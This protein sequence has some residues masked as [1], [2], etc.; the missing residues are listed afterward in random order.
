[1][2]HAS[3]VESLRAHLRDPL[4]RNGYALMLNTGLTA[5]LGFIYWILAAHIYA[6]SI[7]GRASAQIA[8]MMLISALTQINF[9]SVL[10]RFLPRAGLQ[11]RKLV[12]TCYA[13]STSLATVVSSLILIVVHYATNSGTALH[14][15]KPFAIWFVISTAFWSIFNLQDGTMTGLRRTIWVPVENGSFNVVKIILLFAFK[16]ILGDAG[17]F[18]STTIPVLLSLAPVNWAIFKIFIPRHM[19]ETAERA[20]PL[21]LSRI[22]KYIAG[23][24][25]STLFA[26]AMTTLMPVLVIGV[27]GSTDNAYFFIAQTMDMTLDLV[28]FNLASSLTVEAAGHEDR[29]AELSR[30]V[31]RRAMTIVLPLAVFLFVAAPYLLRLFGPQYEANA[32]T[33]LRLLVISS[34]PKV[35]ISFHGALARLK[36]KTYR[37]AIFTSIQA[38]LLVGGAIIFMNHF[39]IN[40]IGY[41]AIISQTFVALLVLPW[42]LKMLQHRAIST[43]KR[44]G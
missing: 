41:A 25:V 32:T 42:V 1:V 14:V 18:A 21:D 15:S 11:S 2:S 31:M 36:H 27:L 20:Q 19:R 29:I 10:I 34:L 43:E 7:V 40:G 24:Y 39:G 44:Q 13:I 22:R 37:N 17:I 33:L 4:Y 26:Q 16:P 9:T 5:F 12:L 38:V 35:I 8:A 30:A 28:A 23:D 6:T 3:R